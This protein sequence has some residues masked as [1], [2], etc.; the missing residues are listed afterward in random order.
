MRNVSYF[1][2]QRSLATELTMIHLENKT[3]AVLVIN[4]LKHGVWAKTTRVVL[5]WTERTGCP[6][7]FRSRDPIL[8]VWT[9]SLFDDPMNWY[10][11][12][13]CSICHSVYQLTVVGSSLLAFRLVH[14]LSTYFI[15]S[16]ALI[17]VLQH[18][19]GLGHEH[20]KRITYA[21]MTATMIYLHSVAAK[22]P[23]AEQSCVN[24]IERQFNVKLYT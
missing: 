14:E 22:R 6:Y 10:I 16:T 9:Q 24:T 13:H 19:I 21:E 1:S 18:N 7:K 12:S 23:E 3:Q 5:R 11:T 15:I 4:G 8:T 2:H 17:C 20:H